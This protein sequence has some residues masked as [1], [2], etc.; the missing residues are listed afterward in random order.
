MKYLLFFFFFT[1]FSLQGIASINYTP[2]DSLIVDRYLHLMQPKRNLPLNQLVI[3]TSRFLLGTPYAAA[4]LEKEPEQLVVNLRELD[5]TT[6][7]ENSLAL[8]LTLKSLHPDFATY[9]KKLQ[10]LRYRNG[11]VT[12]YVSRLHYTTDW[13]AE[14]EKN[15]MLKDITKEIGGTL[16]PVEV[17]FMTT[18]PDKYKQLATNPPLISA[19]S[20]VE[21]ENNNR[22][23]YYIPKA[24]IPSVSKLIRDGD[25]ICFT[26]S[27]KGLDV[28]HVGYAF[29]QNGQ[30]TFIHASTSAN[31]VVINPVSLVDYCRGIRSNTGIIVVRIR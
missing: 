16:L 29:W 23:H 1:S 31:K 3:E 20:V 14:N 18:H 13:I 25:I 7:V 2:E 15:N 22:T 8:S 24:E 6:F 17:S 10:S 9:C 12:G 5:C 19:L 11:E 30:L 28:T 4:T 26:T 27:I 21:K